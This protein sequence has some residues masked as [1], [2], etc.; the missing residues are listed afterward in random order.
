MNIL[1]TVTDETPTEHQGENYLHLVGREPF[2]VESD[3][4]PELTALANAGQLV[5]IEATWDFVEQ[6]LDAK[7]HVIIDG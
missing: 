3:D 2:L 6:V 5:G 4:L 1:Y 7:P